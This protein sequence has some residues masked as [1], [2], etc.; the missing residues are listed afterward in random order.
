MFGGMRKSYWTDT[1]QVFFA[2]AYHVPTHKFLAKN[3][4][5]KL[6]R[7][8]RNFEYNAALISV[9]S[10]AIAQCGLVKN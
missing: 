9:I 2:F 5:A 4:R 10:L 6:I 7:D 8:A 1:D 3:I